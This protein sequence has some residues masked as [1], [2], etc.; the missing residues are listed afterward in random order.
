MLKVA[1][2]NHTNTLLVKLIKG[3][4]PLGSYENIFSD[5]HHTNNF[6]LG[7]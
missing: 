4:Q 1:D 3:M 7:S 2:L 5:Y 6:L